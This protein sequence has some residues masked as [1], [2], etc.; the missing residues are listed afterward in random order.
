M[1]RWVDWFF[2]G[3]VWEVLVMAVNVRCGDVDQVFLMPPSVK[4]W[5]PEGH[6]AFFV[7]DVVSQLD[8]GAFY[9]VY[10]RDGRGGGVYDPAMMVAVLLYAY[11]TGERSSRRIQRRLVEDVAY[12]VLAANQRRRSYDVGEVSVSSSRRYLPIVWSGVG[13]VCE[14][15]FSGC[16]DDRD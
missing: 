14:S 3:G 8:L 16:G 12:R 11:C 9:G 4:E 2:C 10:R 7:V 1:N 15:G 5:L 13:V 6:L